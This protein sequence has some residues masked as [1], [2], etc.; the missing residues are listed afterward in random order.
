MKQRII[1]NVEL[2]D[3]Y[4]EKALKTLRQ[5]KVV[6]ALTRLISSSKPELVDY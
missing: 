1:N 6:T 2:W 3:H 5:N 4:Q